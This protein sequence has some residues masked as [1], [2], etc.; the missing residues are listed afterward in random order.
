V[1]ENQI[2]EIDACPYLGV[3][4]IETSESIVVRNIVGSAGIGMLFT[5]GIDNRVLD[6]RINHCTD[7]GFGIIAD[8]EQGQEI[9]GNTVSTA[10]GGGII[11]M[12][13]LGNTVVSH[14]RLRNCGLAV[15]KSCFGIFVGVATPL[16]N[17]A[18]S[19]TIESCEVIDTG[20]DPNSGSQTTGPAIGIAVKHGSSHISGNRVQYTD[21]SRLDDNSEH[22]SLMIVGMQY[23]I[24][25]T[26]YG[27]CSKALVTANSFSGKGYTAL[28]EFVTSAL[29]LDLVTYSNNMCEHLNFNTNVAAGSSSVILYGTDVVITNNQVTGATGAKSISIALSS[30][31]TLLGNF[32]SGPYDITAPAGQPSVSIKPLNYTSFNY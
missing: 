3:A 8:N 29:K 7:G 19:L 25:P 31:A 27:M 24:T 15:D 26:T 16:W 20:I 6:N 12:N 32:C 5:D 9:R 2:E 17:P 4:L 1:S 21:K 11:L 14:N 23:N 18:D 10:E 30:R 22:R 13:V 28:I